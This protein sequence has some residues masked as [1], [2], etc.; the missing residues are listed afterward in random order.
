MVLDAPAVIRLCP[1]L[2][3]FALCR[4][5]AGVGEVKMVF[6]IATKNDQGAFLVAEK[7]AGC[8]LGSRKTSRVLL[9]PKNTMQEYLSILFNLHQKALK[10]F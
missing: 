7:W 2:E 5:L 9:P 10:V 3:T 6:C 4:S 8:I 1:E